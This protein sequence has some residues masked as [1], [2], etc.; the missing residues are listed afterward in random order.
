MSYDHWGHA[1][2]WSVTV[3][4]DTQLSHAAIFRHF[5]V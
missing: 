4:I 5:Y 2:L 3:V 1:L